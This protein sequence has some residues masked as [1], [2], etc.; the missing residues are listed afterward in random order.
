MVLKKGDFALIPLGVA[1][2]L[3][4]GYEAHVVPRSSTFKNFG[5]IQTNHM[6]VIDESTGKELIKG[7]GKNEADK[8][9]KKKKQVFFSGSSGFHWASFPAARKDLFFVLTSLSASFYQTFLL[10]LSRTSDAA[11][12]FVSSFSISLNDVGCL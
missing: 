11:A 6:G 3:P 8:E 7:F 4:K 12:I 5:I 1:M 10:I 9:V 2:E